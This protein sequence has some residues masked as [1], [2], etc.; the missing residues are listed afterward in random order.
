MTIKEELKEEITRVSEVLA[1]E[2]AL[3]EDD[4]L[5]LFIFSLIEEEQA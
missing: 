4:L 5:S 1:S 3:Q 2:K